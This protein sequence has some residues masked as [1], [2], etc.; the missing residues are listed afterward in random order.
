LLL[1]GSLAAPVA[2]AVGPVA[3]RLRLTADLPFRQFKNIIKN[4]SLL[5]SKYALSLIA[6]QAKKK[7]MRLPGLTGE[8]LACPG[9]R[10]AGY[11]IR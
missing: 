3:L 8:E 6:C 2:L 5:H 11:R 4:L 7:R 10:D 1:V 9:V